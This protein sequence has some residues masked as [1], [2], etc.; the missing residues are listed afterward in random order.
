MAFTGPD[1]NHRTL[2]KEA[3]SK[4]TAPSGLMPN[5]AGYNA[6]AGVPDTVKGG[7]DMYRDDAATMSRPT[8]QA[9]QPRPTQ[10]MTKV[11]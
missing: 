8:D 7:K 9:A 5:D 3:V 6:A 2:R 11:R 10:N 1:V 4:G